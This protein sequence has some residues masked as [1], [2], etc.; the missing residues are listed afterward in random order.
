MASFLLLFVFSAFAILSTAFWWFIL[1][2]V[3]SSSPGEEEADMEYNGGSEKADHLCVLVHG[4]WGKPAHLKSVAKALRDEFSEDRVHILVV[5]SNAG[6]NTYDGVETGGERVCAEIEEELAS[7]ERKRR[8][9]GG[10][11]NKKSGRDD[12]GGDRQIKKLSVVGYSLG[13]LVA[14]Y[15][16]GLLYARGALEGLECMNFTAFASPFLGTRSPL[17]GWANTLF[18]VL[19]ARTLS[20]SGHQLFGIDSFRGTGRPLV[21]VL[22]DPSSIFMAGLRRFKRRTLYANVVNDRTAVYYTTG[23]SKT[24]PFADLEAVT[25]RYVPGYEDVV[26]DRDEP[27]SPR[28]GK[29]QAPPTTSL[30]DAA[31]RYMTRVPLVLALSVLLPVGVVAYL[32]NAGWQTVQSSR[33]RQLHEA[34]QGGVDV[35]PYR[36]SPPLLKDLRQAVEG[37]Y[38][39]ITAANA[40]EYLDHDGGD[41]DDG[42]A[43][44]SSS[45][46]SSGS[47]SDSQHGAAGGDAQEDMLGKKMKKD[48]TKKLT[49]SQSASHDRRV[50]RRERRLSAARAEPTLALAAYQFEA[51]DGLDSL[52]WR[53]YP[54]WIHD[55]GHSHA[56]IIVRMDKPSFREGWVVLRHWVKEEFLL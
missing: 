47:D 36:E 55:V 40:E 49:R 32:A 3:G 33:R 5:K 50:L 10:A 37:A 56:A 29:G 18:N 51:V 12:D 7:I 34:G 2:K 52:G 30:R 20:A 28:G 45:G 44:D 31:H 43:V 13:G 11:D 15:A 19:G 27:C 41:D 4:L 21:A 6:Y 1:R 26:L 8:S 23:I 54:V 16:I 42:G 53:K 14:R 39:E 17:K 24:D 35:A 46:S 25:P 48:K 9:N 38:E 22:A